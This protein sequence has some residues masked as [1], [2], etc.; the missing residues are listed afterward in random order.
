M[1]NCIIFKFW[2]Q[3]CLPQAVSAVIG[4]VANYTGSPLR[5]ES[6]PTGGGFLPKYFQTLCE[7]PKVNWQNHFPRITF[8]CMHDRDSVT[9]ATPAMFLLIFN[10]SATL[11]VLMKLCSAVQDSRGHIFMLFSTVPL[12]SIFLPLN[13]LTCSLYS[14]KQLSHPKTLTWIFFSFSIR[15]STPRLRLRSACPAR[16]NCPVN[17][18]S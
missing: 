10:T 8:F 6:M 17:V 1:I 14:F 12:H 4:I 5:N 9:P 2:F 16:K 3:T 7:Q 11:S 15:E 13:S 18:T